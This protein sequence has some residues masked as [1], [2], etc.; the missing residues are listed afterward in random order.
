MAS[1]NGL[2][3]SSALV[4]KRPSALG[5]F[6]RYI[7]IHQDTPQDSL[8]KACHE[9]WKRVQGL[10]E[11]L[12]PRTSKE[13]LSAPMAGTPRDKRLSFQEEA[14]ELTSSKDEISLLVEQEFLS[15]TKEHLILV[16]EGSGELE[17]LGSSPEGP[18]LSAPR[19]L[20]PS[21]M[22]GSSER[23]GASVM[24]GDKLLEPKVAV[25]VIGSR[26]DCDS[27]MPKVT[28]ILRA[29]KVKSAKGAE[30]RGRSL[31]ASNMEIGQLLSQF[32]LKSTEMPKVPE[33]MVLEETRVIK[34][35]LQNSMFS[36]PGPKEPGGLGPFLLL[37]PPPPPWPLA[38]LDKL[39]EIP[40]PKKQ[41]PVFAKICSKPEAD[42][43]VEEHRLMEWNPGTKELT[44]A[45]Q[46]LLLSQWTQSQKDP[47]G[48][49]G[50]SD[51][52]GSMSVAPPTKKPAWPAEKNLLFNPP[53]T[54]AD[55]NNLKYTG[56][57]STPRFATGLTSA[58][59][60]Q[61]L[62]LNLNYPPPPVFTNPATFPQCQGLHP[63]RAAR[64][65]YQQTLHPQLGCYSRQVTPYS[66]QQMGQQV[67][68]SSYTP[69]LG[70]IP[71]VQPNY[72]YS[73]R[74]PQK[75]SGNPRDPSP[76][77]GDG[78]QCLFPQAFGFGSTSG[79]P[80]MNSPYFSSSGNGINF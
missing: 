60:N 34:D 68:H 73:Q 41:L 19:L 48:E 21:L 36:G 32:P 77:A 13:Q 7:W 11:A 30:D 64:M 29:A 26:Q 40:A 33:E 52:V 79:G 43:A 2:A 8:D 51:P 38:K 28:S 80:L 57:V 5:P 6:P 78:P 27:A 56:N 46:S 17:A 14:L 45:R 55:K 70:Y 25:S 63:Q 15:L 50:C 71:F 72:P 44:K 10:P 18:R 35:F 24:A 75:L 62:W 12:Q 69:L 54:G 66:P 59:L 4:A 37:P 1:G 39:L 23:S 42:P 31:G 74:T 16:T 47:F 3:S 65:P 67:F 22:A 9:I 58:T 53:A 49:E 76:M 61:P 20:M